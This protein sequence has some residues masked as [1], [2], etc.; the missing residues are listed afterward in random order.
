[1]EKHTLI[2][3]VLAAALLGGAS[4]YAQSTP[5]PSP[6]GS[7]IMG[8]DCVSQSQNTELYGF[9]GDKASML[10]KI[11]ALPVKLSE[12]RVFVQ[13]T[14]G[15]SGGEVKYYERQEDGTFTVTQ[16]RVART[17]DLLA[18]IDK[19]VFD[20]KGLKCVGDQVKKILTQ[21]LGPG[22]TVEPLTSSPSPKD[23]FGDSINNASGK[24]IRTT[25]VVL[26]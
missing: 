14:Q 4:V 5:S 9:C 3:T 6:T 2:L 23:A 25:V 7:P 1:M 20:N 24:F 22:K 13:V 16:W 18:T 26:C 19:S 8:R 21:K 10:E 12:R 17:F 15:S 11:A